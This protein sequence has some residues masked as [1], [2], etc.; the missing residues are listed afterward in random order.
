[1]AV[2]TILEIEVKDKAFRDFQK[3]FEGF[4]NA[5][6]ALPDTMAKI[7]SPE[8]EEA[9]GR[10][11]EAISNLAMA[12]NSVSASA[13]TYLDTL[14]T[15]RSITKIGPAAA[16]I[17]PQAA[18]STPATVKPASEKSKDDLDRKDR[19]S[20][21][22][23][24][25]RLVALTGLRTPGLGA[26]MAA[27]EM[28]GPL[29]AL[30]AGGIGYVRNRAPA[31]GGA[32]N[33]A[34]STGIG[35][36][37]Q[38]ALKIEEGEL[39]GVGTL[40]RGLAAANIDVTKS[41]ALAGLG[42]GQAGPGEDRTEQMIE[43][44]RALRGRA[45]ETP[46]QQLE[47]MANAMRL[48]EIGVSGE[49]MRQLKYTSDE[50]AKAIEEHLRTYKDELDLSE[51]QLKAW[52]K[53][54]V[55][56]ERFEAAASNV[57]D[58]VFTPLLEWSNKFFHTGEATD[59]E[60]HPNAVSSLANKWAEIA[61]PGTPG[62]LP[63]ADTYGATHLSTLLEKEK[64]IAK[65]L[66]PD[67]AEALIS[68]DK[69]R[70]YRGE[71]YADFLHN[72]LNLKKPGANG[73]TVF[74]YR[75]FSSFEEGYQAAAKQM[76]RFNPHTVGEAVSRWA[77]DSDKEKYLRDIGRRADEPFNS[78]DVSQLSRLLS[79]MTRKE[80]PDT[81]RYS[82]QQIQVFITKAPGT[83]VYTQVNQGAQ[84]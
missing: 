39:K 30:V 79:E 65:G 74:D 27:Y 34:R 44:L 56:L 21:E 53:L 16:P 5:A 50:E 70:Y 58:K 1:M 12:W 81:P 49:F 2:K 64:L 17:K 72:P 82:P 42:I 55:Q 26:G 45:K 38:E 11:T 35:Y 4:Q 78:Q 57:V 43:V 60:S 22:T 6:K 8:T 63:P 52:Q 46:D 76:Q 62:S 18:T 37:M 25:R 67:Q 84:Q 77:P 31:L 19:K 51:K 23:S 73:G 75:H 13:K 54:N 48:P 80:A 14:R 24:L 32:L 66:P 71:S 7:T 40:A 15:I 59:A 47:P 3:A 68:M 61:A 83:D 33:E 28:F 9:I 20:M 41:T 10:Q 69:A 29:G 36:G